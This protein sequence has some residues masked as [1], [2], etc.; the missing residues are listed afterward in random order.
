MSSSLRVRKMKFRFNISEKK[1]YISLI[2][3]HKKL[4]IRQVKKIKIKNT[5]LKK[6]YKK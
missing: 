6:F 2:A 1:L 5:K 3:S 4:K